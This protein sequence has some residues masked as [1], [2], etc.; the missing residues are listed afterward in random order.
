MVATDAGLRAF[1]QRLREY[2]DAVHATSCPGM[3]FAG[4]GPTD[5]FADAYGLTNTHGLVDAA[6]TRQEL[7]RSTH[8]GTRGAG[9]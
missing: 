2:H 8:S 1:A 3:T 4:R 9:P 5:V 7:V 6:I